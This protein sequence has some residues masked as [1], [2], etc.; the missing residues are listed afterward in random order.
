MIVAR[1][2]LVPRHL[3]CA[4]KTDRVI[5]RDLSPG[6]YIIEQRFPL[7]QGTITV[8]AKIQ[9]A[10]AVNRK[11]R[12]AI[13]IRAAGKIQARNSDLVCKLAVLILSRDC[14]PV[15]REA[16]AHIGQQSRAE[17]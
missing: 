14:H 2:A 12:Q 3:P 7:M 17:C 10:R 8:V 4:T 11:I 6:A 16:K 15:A 9:S 1:K 13:S 5:T